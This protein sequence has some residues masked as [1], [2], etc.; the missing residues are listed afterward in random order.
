[1]VSELKLKYSSGFSIISLR[2]ANILLLIYDMAM[3]FVDEIC[4]A[5]ILMRR[6][7]ICFADGS[8]TL[9]ERATCGPSRID[10]CSVTLNAVLR[11]SCKNNINSGAILETTV[12][13]TVN[14]N[15]EEINKCITDHAGKIKL[16]TGFIK[17]SDQTRSPTL[18]IKVTGKNCCNFFCNES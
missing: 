16:V 3:T 10:T 17:F 9:F 8:P 5:A 13:T 14:S 6:T 2:T 18:Q 7:G 4:S 15:L 11:V 1:M 12:P